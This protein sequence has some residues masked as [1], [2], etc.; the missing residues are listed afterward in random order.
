MIGLGNWI[1]V[2]LFSGKFRFLVNSWDG[3][4]FFFGVEGK[5][6]II[7]VIFGNYFV[8]VR[9]VNFGIKLISF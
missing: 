8:I 2:D 7:L 1:K 9:R 4:Y 6:Y 3:K 5:I